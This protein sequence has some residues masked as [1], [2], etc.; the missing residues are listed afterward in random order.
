MP[1]RLRLW[2]SARV[3]ASWPPPAF[4]SARRAA[5]SPRQRARLLRRPRPSRRS[6]RP[7]NARKVLLGRLQRFGKRS[8]QAS[9]GGAGLIVVPSHSGSLF[10]THELLVQT[11]QVLRRHSV[12]FTRRAARCCGVGGRH[13]LRPASNQGRG[14][15]TSWGRRARVF[16][17]QEWSRHPGIPS[18]ELPKV[19]SRCPRSSP[20][21]ARKSAREK[22]APTSSPYIVKHMAASAERSVQ[23]ILRSNQNILAED[24]VNGLLSS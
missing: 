14:R 5:S 15:L 1:P 8:W 7:G 3:K 10:E 12:A 9:G 18:S 4:R 6:I 16:D 11:R 22:G 17:S 21:G 24:F 20:P 23:R 2:A 19:L 13:P